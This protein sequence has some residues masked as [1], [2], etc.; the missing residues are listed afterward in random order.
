M[1]ALIHTMEYFLPLYIHDI[2]SS[3]VIEAMLLSADG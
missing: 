1:C 2:N 3:N